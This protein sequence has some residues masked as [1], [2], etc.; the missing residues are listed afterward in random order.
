MKPSLTVGTGFTQ[1]WESASAAAVAQHLGS[2]VSPDSA[3]QVFW[4]VQQIGHLWQ[5]PVTTLGT[6]D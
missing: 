6:G 5:V 1:F 4:A 3:R 2:I